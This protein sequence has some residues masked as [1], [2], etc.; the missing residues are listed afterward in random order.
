MVMYR[1]PFLPAINENS[2]VYKTMRTRL[3]TKQNKVK[4]VLIFFRQKIKIKKINMNHPTYIN[5]FR[6][7]ALL[8]L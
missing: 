4:F 8:N 5:A 3:Y 6:S 1:K 7:E 2:S